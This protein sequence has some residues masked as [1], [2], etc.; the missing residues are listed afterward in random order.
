VTKLSDCETRGFWSVI[1]FLLG[2]NV[3]C[4]LPGWISS[5]L[6]AEQL[7]PVSP[8]TD[9]TGIGIVALIG[10][11]LVGVVGVILYYRKPGLQPGEEALTRL[12]DLLHGAHKTIAAQATVIQAQASAATPSATSAPAA[13][14]VF[15]GLTF[16]D[17][18]S[19]DDYKAA[20]GG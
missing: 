14:L 15:N 4:W 1:Y 10:A 18:K 8:P 5:A 9:W 2:V 13:G 19:L 12:M 3:G 7:T 16:A 20:K 11:L 17:Q 6:A